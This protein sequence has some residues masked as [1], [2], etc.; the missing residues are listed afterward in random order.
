MSKIGTLHRCT[1]AITAALFVCLALAACGGGS[2]ESTSGTNSAEGG[3]TLTTA[4]YTAVETQQP[5]SLLDPANFYGAEALLITNSA[6]EG[7]VAYQTDPATSKIEPALAEKWTVSPDGKTYTFNLR[8][9]AKYANGK[10]MTAED[11]VWS[12]E[13]FKDL[14][15]GPSYMLAEMSK[16]AAPNPSTVVITLK[17]RS[18]PFLDYLASP[19]GPKVIDKS[20]V[21]EAN[22]AKQGQQWLATHTA[23]TGPYQVSS[24]SPQE[25][26]MEANPNYWNGAPKLSKINI[27]IIE[28]A[29]ARNAAMSSGELQLLRLDQPADY[30]QFE[31]ESGFQT[32]T[33][34]SLA[35][36]FL[37][38]N[39]T[40]APFDD[41]A[42]REALS[43]AI[44]RPKIVEQIW[45]KLA[46]PSEQ[47]LPAGMMEPT[48]DPDPIKYD[49]GKALRADVAKLSTADRNVKLVYNTFFKQDQRVAE[50]LASTLEEA[51]LN[52]QLFQPSPGQ[53]WWEPNPPQLFVDTSNPDSAN[54]DS[55][56]RIFFNTEGELNYLN[57]GTKEADEL[58]DK[59]ATSKSEKEALKYYSEAAKSVQKS[60]T[61]ISLADPLN[62]N[63]AVE[64]LSGWG[65]NIAAPFSLV[66]N[67][68]S[69]GE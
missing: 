59:G 39:P 66:L 50:I 31:N 55:W 46:S 69:L 54:P 52:V 1:L 28:D 48:E 11:V 32:F 16:I 20:Q 22:D 61:F 8:S 38:V 49:G 60:N 25:I 2:K 36:Q 21:K 5:G 41:P 58:M 24:Y 47:M 12:F 23:G 33:E 34:P 37:A 19:Y 53:T 26:V 45:G 35:H 3:G 30:G 64:G 40:S 68:A 6:Y 51:G 56:M 67:S 29:S 62:A 14:E 7:L 63:T 44:D 15:G 65:A 17:Q 42:M 10:A 13:R 57:G 27:K 9:D 43:A 18:F 4:M